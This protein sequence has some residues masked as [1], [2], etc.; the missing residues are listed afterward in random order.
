MSTLTP[1][2]QFD[3]KSTYKDKSSGVTKVKDHSENHYNGT[4]ETGC[5]IVNDPIMGDCLNFEGTG[6]VSLPSLP[7]TGDTD[8]SKGITITTWINF[9]QLSNNTCILELN[10]S[11]QDITLQM[12]ENNQPR[13][14]VTGPFILSATE[15][16]EDKWYHLAATIDTLGN[17]VFY[18]NGNE[19]VKKTDAN[20]C[21]KNVA[22]TSNF[23]GRGADGFAGTP[24]FNGKMAWLSVYNTALT[25]DEV[26][27][28]MLEGESNRRSLTPALQ[29]DFKSIDS[30]KIANSPNSLYD[31]TV[32]PG[33]TIVNDPIM[34]N[35]LQFDGDTGYVK[36]PSLPGTGTTD[37]STAMTIAVWVKHTDIK[38]ISKARSLLSF[39]QSPDTNT[40]YNISFGQEEVTSSAYFAVGNPHIAD[41]WNQSKSSQP[42]E[43]DTWQH[44]AVVVD[45]QGKFCIY[46]N[47][48]LVDSAMDN[49]PSILLKSLFPTDTKEWSNN[50]IGKGYWDSKFFE[51]RLAW[52]SVY[53]FPLTKDQVNEDMLL[54]ESNRISTF[55]KSLPVDFKVYSDNNTDHVPVLYIEKEGKGKKIHLEV[56]NNSKKLNI[57]TATGSGADLIASASNYH[58]QLH[59]RPGTLSQNF[60]NPNP[61]N[62]P[63]P[64]KIDKTDLEIT[65]GIDT[66]NKNDHWSVVVGSDSANGT[67]YISFLRTGSPIPLVQN[68]KLKISIDGVNANALGGTRNTN[69]EFRYDQVTLGEAD[70]TIK[71]SRIQSLSIVS[72]L[73]QKD[74]P[75]HVDVVGAPVILNDGNAKTPNEL[76]FRI[77]N[78]SSNSIPL[79][80]TVNA[81]TIFEVDV[82]TQPGGEMVEWALVHSVGEAMT[83]TWPILGIVKTSTTNSTTITLEESVSKK[84]SAG[85]QINIKPKVGE[86]FS[87]TLATDVVE[88]ALTITSKEA[89]SITEGSIVS[90]VP[91]LGSVKTATTS[92]KSI[93][94]TNSLDVN[95]KTGRLLTITPLIGN[96]IPV[97]LAANANARTSI[98]TIT[99]AQSIPEGSI[100]S[101]ASGED[102]W[103]HIKSPATKGLVQW[104]ITNLL[105]ADLRGG[106]SIEFLLKDI[107]CGLPAGQ[108][109]ITI[110]YSNIPGYWP[111]EFIIPIQKSPIITQKQNVGINLLPAQNAYLNLPYP[112]LGKTPLI[113][114]SLVIGDATQCKSVNNAG[115]DQ[116]G[117]VV[118]V[119]KAEST[120]ASPFLILDDTGGDI[121]SIDT[122]GNLN[123]ESG[124]VTTASLT[125]TGD[126]NTGEG[127][128]TTEGLTVTGQ[129][130]LGNY[131]SNG[132]VPACT[133]DGEEGALSVSWNKNGLQGVN[134]I[135]LKS[136]PGSTGNAFTFGQYNSPGKVVDDFM[137][138]KSSGNVGIGTKS[139]SAKLDVNGEI[140]ATNLTTTGNTSTASLNV[141]GKTTLGSY[142]AEN[143]G[144][145][146]IATEGG[147]GVSWNKLGKQGVNLV[148]LIANP[149]ADGSAF[150][151]GQYNSAGSALMQDYMTIKCSGYVGI[152]TTS[153]KAPLHVKPTK[154]ITIGE[155][156]YFAPPGPNSTSTT[157]GT[158]PVNASIK[159]DGVII[160]VGVYTV[161]DQRIKNIE[162]QSKTQEDLETLLQLKITNYSYIDTIGKGA[163]FQKALIAQQ[164]EKVY[165]L[166]VSESIDFIPNIYL[167]SSSCKVNETDKTLTI[168]LDKAHELI[169]GDLVKLIDEQNKELENEVVAIID[170]NSFTV[171]DWE[172]TT[173]KIFVFGKQVDDFRTVDYNQV[174]MLGISAIQALNS[175]VETLE[176]EVSTLKKEM[177][178]L[179]EMVR[180]NNK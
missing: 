55:R 45:Q 157:S 19:I 111:G 154:S 27:A 170:A 37:F 73:G 108:S 138:I 126:I 143:Y 101:L 122:K 13:C 179:K 168:T 145:P 33:C 14:Y 39:S 2:L 86:I 112:T 82:L 80:T 26:N 43:K 109:F 129:T 35:C 5:T 83:L 87:I 3:F 152:G 76:L 174:S 60:L 100:V 85:T 15:L 144:V 53:N 48:E 178:L 44:Y 65:V 79:S 128:I 59:F 56:I 148:N 120:S 30:G 118:V 95:L 29:F 164:V 105:L 158:L 151:F 70:S 58:F 171:K 62:T 71:G 23:I 140:S 20:L 42:F 177:E 28:D 169:V 121:L 123:T 159:S 75:L 149:G 77:E 40:G 10:S 8:L 12:S 153:P 115:G 49:N 94:L 72:H 9:G 88:G 18:I 117:I 173:E 41:L 133:A 47:G 89:Q 172:T 46:L 84:L 161:S 156:N 57:P 180:N 54:G 163:G 24:I 51:G 92:S 61:Q 134:L 114:N 160:C 141:T 127:T 119:E 90:V 91:H 116:G 102:L 25:I 22:S 104:T 175:K 107:V 150:T 4:V 167:L 99:D 162:Q 74:I 36:I 103:K 66:T 32:N 34:G 21:P 125:T 136:N 131:N 78:T 16:K 52:L 139:P 124:S 176:T 69:V 155:Y 81:P 96:E 98:L 64:R 106:G 68:E 67:E 93:T 166:A 38:A 137:T 11:T 147:L 63:N 50:Y 31:A 132:G 146:A 135:N 113:Q 142:N 165:P 17:S 97:T 6:F 110:K 7:D 1:S 130:I